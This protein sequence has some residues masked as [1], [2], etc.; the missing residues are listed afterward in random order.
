[1]KKILAIGVLAIGMM[2][3]SQQ[4]ASAWVN[5]RF[6]MGL[7]FD[8]SSGGNT[9]LWGL[10]RDG[11]PGAPDHQSWLHERFKQNHPPRAPYYYPQPQMVPAPVPA[12]APGA[13]RS[14]EAPVTPNQGFQTSPYAPQ[15]YL[16]SPFAPQYQTAPFGVQSFYQ[17]PYMAPGQFANYPMQQ[18]YYYPQY[19][20]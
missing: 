5:T 1:M 13:P 12:P 6:G 10:I 7:N 19:G 8:W 15:G 17:M 2:A 20:R 3:I 4:Q 16:P 18:N 11:Q 14:F 9:L